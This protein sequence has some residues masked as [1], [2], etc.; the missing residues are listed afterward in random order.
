M[1]LGLGTVQFGMPYGIS[2]KQGRVSAAKAERILLV[3]S[4]AGVDTLD[5]A[6]AYGV[7]QK[8]LGDSRIGEFGFK[9][10]TK[11]PIEGDPGVWRQ[12]LEASLHELGV[13]HAHG[14]LAHRPAD[15]LGTRSRE[16]LD[17]LF[18][19]RADGLVAKVGTSVYSIAEVDALFSTA[20][21]GR[22][23]DLVQLP[24]SI[25]DWR[26][27]RSGRL[28]RLKESGVEIHVRSAF[29][30]GLLFMN[31]KELPLPLAG[32]ARALSRIS[33]V[34]EELGVRR[35]ALAL[36]FLKSMGLVDVVVCG[37]TSAAEL[38]QLIDD[39][40]WKCPE[41]FSWDEFEIQDETILNP[42]LWRSS[43]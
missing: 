23:L 39:F 29:L 18:R 21:S 14:W 1:R 34:S 20:E 41:G 13:Q 24:A 5:T 30:Q 12:S 25:F 3:A 22:S 11:T 16:A 2:N 37:V 33:A 8:T 7:S 6:P 4:G 19:A 26:M 9:I 42:S 10:V 31:E 15:L 32:A 17:V 28:L 36:G 35:S 38:E 43:A 27:L 40:N